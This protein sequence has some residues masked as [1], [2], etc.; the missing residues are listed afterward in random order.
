MRIY[1]TLTKKKE[2][3]KPLGNELLIYLCGPTVYNFIHVGNA[4]T[5]CVFDVFRRYLSYKKIPFKFV[6]NYTDIDDRIIDGANENNMPAKEYAEKYIDEFLVDSNGL[7]ITPPSVTPRA[8]ESIDAILEIIDNLVDNGHAYVAENSDVYFRTRSFEDYGKLS[9]QD[10]EQIEEG[11][12]IEYNDVKEDPMD[13]V[14]WKS[15][16]PGEP[17]WE[18]RYGNGR[19]GWHIECSAMAKKHLGKTIDVHCGGLD[20]VF[21]HHEN[22]IA[23]SESYSGEVFSRYWMHVAMINVDNRKMSKSLG[24]FFTVREISDIYGYEPIR[25]FL[26]NA[27][28]RSQI[29]FSKKAIE[30]SLAS[31]KRINIARENL[32]RAIESADSSGEDILL[33]SAKKRLGQFETS[34]D[35]DLNTA[36]AIAAL[37]DLIRDINTS[38]GQSK[39]S[40]SKTAEIFDIMT[41]VLG[42]KAETDGDDIP[43]EV[44]QLLE[45]RKRSRENKNY[46]ESDR[47]REV[48]LEKGYR[49]EDT[50]DGQ[51]LRKNN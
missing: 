27:H 44:I 31:L 47:L 8:T 21:P 29:N 48:L 14:L 36:D 30:S 24:N 41:G 25:F 11:H 4:R 7:S 50:K 1:N 18:S 10:I 32:E 33:D 5:L 46:A 39:D 42:I 23:Q 38:E 45:E 40:L 51:V 13:F 49:V 28:Y 9:N 34:M 26:I 3:L 6:M 16:K 37:F 43:P 22:E 17:S 12:R 15:S 20:L 35:D 19:P 2:E